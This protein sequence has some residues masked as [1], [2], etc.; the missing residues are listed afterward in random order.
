MFAI[1]AVDLGQR[2]VEAVDVAMESGD[3]FYDV[4][5]PTAAP[6]GVRLA[7]LTDAF[8]SD[9]PYVEVGEVHC[10]SGR[11]LVDAR[12]AAGFA[13]AH[14]FTVSPGSDWVVE[15]HYNDGWHGLRVRRL[16]AHA[17]ITQVRVRQSMCFGECPAFELTMRADGAASW[18]GSA[19]VDPLG[20]A[21]GAITAAAFARV[22]QAV[23]DEGFDD[24]PRTLWAEV[25]V[26]DAPDAMLEVRRGRSWRRVVQ[27]FP[28][29]PPGFARITARALAAVR[30]LGW[31]ATG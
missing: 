21:T 4:T 23:V 29:E 18:E 28:H 17:E 6:D 14:V 13:D 9:I 26:D 19:W 2:G 25:S 7:T 15:L 5:G 31:A 24:W 10:A 12:G 16:Q 3:G 1:D 27:K 20:S 11:L 30:P 22:A 8:D